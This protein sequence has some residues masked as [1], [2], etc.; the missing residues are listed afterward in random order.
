MKDLIK[1][2]LVFVIVFILFFALGYFYNSR[3]NEP[4]SIITSTSDTVYLKDTAKHITISNH[5]YSKTYTVIPI[6]N[7]DT[8]AILKNY[9]T[10]RFIADTLNDSLIR[11]VIFDTLYHNNLMYR[12]R[13]YELLKPY[14][15]QITTTHSITVTV[16]Q[17]GF[18]AGAFFGFN[19]SVLQ[20]AG[21]EAN[22]ITHKFNY[23]LGYDFK[24]N[25]VT[26][27]LLINLR[28]K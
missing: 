6:G 10:K 26:G 21:L 2:L 15:K 22:Y 11:I 14:Q 19:S 18:Y 24:N 20:S 16:S 17:K 27:K 13:Q 23:G 9:Y 5:F 4:Q 25:T 1:P 8:S 3:T 7:I 28:T 12:K